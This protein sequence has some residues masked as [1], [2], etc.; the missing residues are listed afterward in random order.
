[1]KGNIMKTYQ[2]KYKL[3]F[4]FL[5]ML[6]SGL[7]RGQQPIDSMVYT[8]HA[9]QYIFQCRKATSI[10]LF[11]AANLYVS[12]QNGYWGDVHG[13]PYNGKASLPDTIKERK[14]TDGNIFTPPTSPADTGMYKFYFYFTSAKEYCGIKNGTRFILNLYLGSYGCFT[15]PATGDLDNSH[16]F[17]YDSS[18]DMNINGL[19][20]FNRPVT[21]ESLLL[22]FSREPVSWK[23]DRSMNSDWVEIDVYTDRERTPQNRIGNGDM[24]VRLDSAYSVTYYVIIHPDNQNEVWDSLNITV[25]PEPQLEVIYS[26]DILVDQNREYGIDDGISITV[27][28]SEDFNY[29]KFLLNDKSL[30]KYYLGGDTT[31]NEI[32]L[33]ALAF[34][35]VEDFLEIIATD[36]NNCIA[37]EENNVIVRVPFPTVFTPDGDGVNDIFLGGEKF[38]NREFHLEIHNRWGNRLYSG[39]SG[40]DGTYRGNKVPP[41]TYMYVLILKMEDGSSKTVKNTVTL[42]RER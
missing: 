31:K 11:K 24:E 28:N 17:C 33:S 41:G 22:Q 40:W 30:N 21:V 2:H 8:V 9:P 15:T 4:F 36:K 19:H 1:M 3:A 32:V 38:R 12:P 42:I 27:S 7:A 10:D 6:V 16:Y 25:Y 5:S 13:I 23:K 35:G 20:T 37:R 26:P 18:V 29:F 14:Y 34:S 39:E